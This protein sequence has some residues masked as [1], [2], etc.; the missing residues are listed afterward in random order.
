MNR[1]AGY[2]GLFAVMGCNVVANVLMKFGA[3]TERVLFG[4]WSWPTLI[5]ILLFS[6]GVVILSWVLRSLTLHDTQIVGS[7]Q[8]VGVILA[9]AFVLG[10]HIVPMKWFGIVLITIG[11]AICLRSPEAEEL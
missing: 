6:L 10:E 11:I 1:A 7:L 4:I 8:Y 3:G 2:A 9:S 5:G